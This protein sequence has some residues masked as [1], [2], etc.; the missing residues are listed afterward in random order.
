MIIN[1]SRYI[2][3]TP[4]ITDESIVGSSAFLLEKKRCRY[5]VLLSTPKR[6]VLVGS[7]MELHEGCVCVLAF[8]NCSDVSIFIEVCD[9]YNLEK[10]AF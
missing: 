2:P 1:P 8:F 7:Y 4:P 5:Y 6:K 10:F 9:Y 3:P